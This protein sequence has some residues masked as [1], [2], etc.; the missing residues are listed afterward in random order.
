MRS[1][2]SLVLGCSTLVAYAGCG[3]GDPAGPA[4]T[5]SGGASS[6]SS[7][8]TSSTSTSTSSGSSSTSSS[9]SSTSTSS[10]GAC[11]ADGLLGPLGKTHIIVG[12]SMDDTVAAAAPFDLRYQ[13]LSG[14]LFDGDAPCASCATGCTAGGTSCDNAGGGCAWWG[15]WQSDQD[16]PGAFLRDLLTKSKANG[17]IPM[18]S[19]YMIL[20]TSGVQ[21]GSAEVTDAA[22]DPA[23]MKRVFADWR[24][25]C[26]QVGSATAFLQF[27]PDFWGYAEQVN[28]NPHMMPAAVDS[29]NPTDC[30]GQENT[31]A[32]LGHCVIAMVRKYAPAARVGLHASDWG[33]KMDVLQ[34]KA[35]AFDVAGEAKK[36]GTFMK[37]CG[38]DQG[39]FVTVDASDRDAGYYQ[40]I[41]KDVW[42]DKTNATLPNFHQ[43]FTWAK[44]LAETVGRPIVEWQ[45][46]VGNE[47]LPDMDTQWKD[48]RVDYFFAHMDEVAAANIAAVAYGS[49]A[50]GQTDPS[51]DGGNLVSKMKA[52][53]AGGGQKSCK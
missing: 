49:G 7:G 20:Q 44:A 26:Q 8:M 6:T 43:A 48:N 4:P 30:A 32:G 5:G 52:Y 15:C 38:A 40:S 45:V 29:A 39:D 22:N 13:Y 27:E 23:V 19:Y 24:F 42:W 33:A 9:T 1:F 25:V 51:T 18:V 47:S 17:E 11:L 21:E 34:N 31:I 14:G 46:P 12:A 28:E 53:A 10:S 50:T 37:A 35:P 36:L 3:G 2:V 41:G 16:P